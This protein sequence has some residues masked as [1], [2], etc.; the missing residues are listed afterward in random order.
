[1]GILPNMYPYTILIDRLC[2]NGRLKDAQ[3]VVEG[4]L[5]KGYDSWVL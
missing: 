2:K 5:G 1:M 4:R 3:E